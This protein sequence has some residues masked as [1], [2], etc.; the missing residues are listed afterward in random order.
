MRV[1]LAVAAVLMLVIPCEAGAQQAPPVNVVPRAATRSYP[2][3]PPDARGAGVSPVAIV[4]VTIDATGAVTDAQPAAGEPALVQAAV[5]AAR[6][7]RFQAPD[8]AP[9]TTLVGINFAP[10]GQPDAGALAMAAP[11]AAATRVSPALIQQ[12]GN[13]IVR[14]VPLSGPVADPTDVVLDMSIDG[15]GIPMSAHALGRLNQ[16]SLPAL[17]AALAWPFRPQADG[18]TRTEIV[19]VAFMMQPRKIK[20]ARPVYPAAAMRKKVTGTVIIDAMIGTDGR[21]QEAAIRQ[22]IPDLD[23]AAL[24]T[25]R[26]W[27]FTPALRNG[28]PFPLKITVSVGFGQR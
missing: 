12:W 6:R 5:D 14:V 19:A 1:R 13:P 22:S 28:V 9:V 17:Q 27:E 18:A 11:A 7:W 26:Q 2:V 16:F 24:A 4:Q 21:V 25:V 10:A 20:D 23:D 8:A 15:A 3:V